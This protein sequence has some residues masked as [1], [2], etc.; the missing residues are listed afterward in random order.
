MFLSLKPNPPGVSIAYKLYFLFG[1]FLKNNKCT[2]KI[3]LPL[4]LKVLRY[5]RKI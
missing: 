4:F 5:H 3:L 1:V 2:T